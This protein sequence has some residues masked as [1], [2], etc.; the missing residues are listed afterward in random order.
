MGRKGTPGGT[1]ELRAQDQVL[2]LARTASDV[3]ER[4]GRDTEVWDAFLGSPQ[5]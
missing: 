1:C 2:R 3:L 4:Q 5:S